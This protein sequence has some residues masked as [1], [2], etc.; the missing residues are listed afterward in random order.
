MPGVQENEGE[1]QFA[2]LEDGAALRCLLCGYVSHNPNDVAHRYCPNCRLY[3]DPETAVG[4]RCEAS[5]EP[6][7][8]RRHPAAQGVL[9]PACGTW[10]PLRETNW[11]QERPGEEWVT[12]PAHRNRLASGPHRLPLR[13]RARGQGATR[14]RHESQSDRR[15]EETVPAQP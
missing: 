9:C 8:Y 13:G 4:V 14:T 11:R 6:F 3:L 5:G 2:V 1:P 12:L 7:L 10:F 15:R